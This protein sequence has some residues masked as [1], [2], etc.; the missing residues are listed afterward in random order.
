MESI[1]CIS[2]FWNAGRFTYA[3][4]VQEIIWVEEIIW[5]IKI[6]MEY[7]WIMKVEW[8]KYKS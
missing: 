2:D 4:E 7:N 3:L 8:K 6:V 5:N 1:A